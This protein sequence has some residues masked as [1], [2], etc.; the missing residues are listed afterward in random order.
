MAHQKNW[1]ATVTLPGSAVFI[2]GVKAMGL[3][4]AILKAAELA[5]EIGTAEHL[6]MTR[7]YGLHQPQLLAAHA[8]GEI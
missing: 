4:Q 6:T 7:L 2:S 8:R 1:Q 3:P 5:T